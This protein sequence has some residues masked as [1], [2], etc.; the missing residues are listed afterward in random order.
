M[1]EQKGLDHFGAG[2]TVTERAR[3]REW[4]KKLEAA[5][6]KSLAPAGQNAVVYLVVDCSSSMA[7]GDKMDQAK[8][9]ALGYAEGAQRKRYDVGLIKFA[10]ESEHLVEPQRRLAHLAAKIQDMEPRG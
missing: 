10:S 4:V 2:R 3:Q 8:R 5:S 1:S 9:G 7:E 6:G